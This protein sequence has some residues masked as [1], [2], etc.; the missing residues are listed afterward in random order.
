MTKNAIIFHGTGGNPDAVW[1]PWLDRTLT[2]RGYRVERPHHPG[3]NVEPIAEFL[4][5]VLSAHDFDAETV[6]IGHSGG[7]ALLLALVENLQAPIA[8]T[9]LVAGY[10]TQLGDSDEPVLQKEYDWGRIRALGGDFVFLNS[11]VDPYG[12]DADQ[13]RLMFDHLGGTQIIRNDGHFGDH[14]QPFDTFELL[15]RLIR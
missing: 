15:D 9:V 12:C 5:T 3:I 11:V 2:G 14:D 7:A 13:G 6:L 4:P 1:Y 8:Q 10:A